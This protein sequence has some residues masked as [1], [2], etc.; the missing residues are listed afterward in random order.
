MVLLST[1][2]IFF[3]LENKKNNF[4]LHTLICR[5]GCNLQIQFYGNPWS[6]IN[7]S[8]NQKENFA[9]LDFSD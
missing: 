9:L 2:N 7:N 3:A 8:D 1:N 4:Q 6:S 5:P